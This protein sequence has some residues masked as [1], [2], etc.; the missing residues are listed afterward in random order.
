MF[1]FTYVYLHLIELQH[2]NPQVLNSEAD[3]LNLNMYHQPTMKTRKFSHILPSV[4]LGDW[5]QSH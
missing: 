2:L 1:C 5:N 4:I 3:I